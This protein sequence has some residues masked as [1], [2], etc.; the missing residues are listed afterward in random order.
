ET[1]HPT[2]N[3]GWSARVVPTRIAITGNNTWTLV[4]LLAL[5]VGFVLFIAC[6]N[7]ANLMLVRGSGRR[8]EIAVRAAL[9]AG[10]LRI[11]GQLMS[12]SLVIGLIGGACGLAIASAG[13]RLMRAASDDTFFQWVTID[14]RVLA[15]TVV[16]SLVTPLVFSAVPAFQAARRDL[17]DAL[18]D[19]A[20]GSGDARSNR[21]RAVLVVSQL[22]L[23]LA[24]MIV[25]GL[26]V[27]A[28]IAMA[29][30]PLGFDQHNLLTMRVEL[31]AWK[32]RSD[33][34]VTRFWDGL[35]PALS[36]V[37][38]VS[39]IAAG[40]RTPVVDSGTTASLDI[41]GRAND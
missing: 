25:A 5:V 32:Y 31:P 15:F 6:A 34:E 10:R 2:T 12:E 28:M 37:P 23:A 39:A 16:L 19:G 1:D 13:L 9:G 4:G 7:L 30:A 22:T 14:G 41:E 33:A 38:G 17:T 27:R 26:T 29:R 18:R 20:R 35:L 8:K 3:A 24:L 36:S 11:V 40:S 21:G